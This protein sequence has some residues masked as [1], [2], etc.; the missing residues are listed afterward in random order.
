MRQGGPPVMV[1]A[2]GGTLLDCSPDGRW[3]VRRGTEGFLLTATEG[4]EEHAVAGDDAYASR[5]DNSA[6]FG[7]QG[8]VLYLLGLDRRSIDVLDVV[9]RRTRRTIVFD[10][11][12][13]DRIEGFAFNSAGTRVLLTTGG[14]R[15]DLWM[16]GGFA[17]PST[18]WS[19]WFAHWESS[20]NPIEVP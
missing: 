20:P 2:T 16:A 13:E 1:E 6:Q 19:R 10:T 18:A 11:P 12:S 7:E 15:N 17:R 14:D 3:L 5:A 9:T 8:Q 4:G